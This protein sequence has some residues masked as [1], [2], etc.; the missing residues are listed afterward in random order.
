MCNN[1]NTYC[2]FELT[3][4]PCPFLYTQTCRSI[5]KESWT[6]FFD[7][8]KE[9]ICRNCLHYLV[10]KEYSSMNITDFSTACHLFEESKSD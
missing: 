1:Y 4:K 10:C 3:D 6:T 2:I 7:A 9:E 5:T 8:N